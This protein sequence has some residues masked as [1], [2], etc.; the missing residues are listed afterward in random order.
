V[1]NTDFAGGVDAPGRA[2]ISARTLRE[3][4]W[5]LAPL[6]TFIGLTAFVLCPSCSASG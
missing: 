6:L 1:T 3:D 4:R 5:W 2:R